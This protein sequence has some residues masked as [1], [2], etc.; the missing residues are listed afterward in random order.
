MPIRVSEIAKKL[1]IDH[2]IVLAKAKELGVV[3]WLASSSLDKITA[4]YLETKLL[5]DLAAA[6][7]RGLLGIG[8]GSFKAFAEMQSVPLRPLTL[9]FG[10]NS[11]GKSSLIHGLLLARHAIKTG[12]LDAT[13][14]EIGGDSVDLGGFR[15]YVHRRQADRRVELAVELDNRALMGSAS[16]LLQKHKSTK[17]TLTIGV[18]L[19]D[20]GQPRR[21]EAPRLVSYEVECG[22]HSVLRLSGRPD[23]TMQLDRLDEDTLL[24]MTDDVGFSNWTTRRVSSEADKKIIQDAA[25]PLI[26]MLRFTCQRWLPSRLLSEVFERGRQGQRV[27][28]RRARRA[29]ELVEATWEHLP[30]YIESLISSAY[31]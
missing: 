3:A 25:Q 30:R 29:E 21:D 11:S 16:R 18:P 23:K 24:L 6:F 2:R 26:P 27:P 5:D 31:A 8:L 15:Q 4:E 1:G 12:E 19:D 9:V 17:V 20:V 7:R 28:M 13:R 22:G 10:A 14:T